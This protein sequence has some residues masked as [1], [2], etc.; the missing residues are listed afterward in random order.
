MR[1]SR[2]EFLQGSAVAGS[3]LAAA[4]APALAQQQ[5]APPAS[6]PA[7]FAFDR[8]VDEASR[9]AAQKFQPYAVEAPPPFNNIGYDQYRDIVF[10]PDAAIWLREPSFFRLEFFHSGFIYKQPVQIFLVEDAQAKPLAFSPDYFT[11]GYGGL[12]PPTNLTGLGFAGFR[13]RAPISQPDVYEEVIAFLGASYF[14]AVARNI[15]YGLS[16]RGLAIDTAEPTGEEFPTFRKFW[17]EKPSAGSDRLVISA[18]LDS[19]SAAG[20]YRFTLTTGAETAISVDATLFPRKDIK[21]AGLAPLTSMFLFDDM[22]HSRVD[23]FRRAVHDSDGLQMLSGGGEWIY[24]PLSNPR[25]LQVSDF[26]DRSPRGFGL[27]QRAR[28]YS[29]YEDAE[30]RYERRPSVWIEPV[31]DWGAGVV[32][33]V[34]IPSERE[35]NDNIVA[36]WRPDTKLPTLQPYRFLYRMRWLDDLLPPPELLWVAASR[37]G[38]SLDRSRRIFVIDFRKGPDGATIANDD[39]WKVVATA[40]RGTVMNT[41]YYMVPSQNVLR[42]SFEFDPGSDK[43]SE[44]RALLTRGGKVASQTW[45]YRWTP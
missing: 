2:R 22:N 12:T 14:R 1:I 33:L 42:V 25:T 16:A 20:A 38:S 23:D 21:R 24:R 9:L 31:N 41:T 17:I 11:Y 44:L 35:A 39:G 10:R 15:G 5:P 40:S 43:L 3:W 32:E 26:V 8:V 34:E 27:M 7:L 37:S 45:L 28:A 6:A 18:L 30:A 13:V 4:A 29:D 19:P 36:Y